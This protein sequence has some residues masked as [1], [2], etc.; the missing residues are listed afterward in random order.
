MTDSPAC[1]Q[2]GEVTELGG[3]EFRVDGEVEP[4]EGGLFFE[5]GAADPSVQRGGLAAGDLVLA[6][7]L[8]ELEVAEFAGAGL[9]QASVERVEHSREFEFS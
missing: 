3:G 8:E 5:P 4:F 6:E 7:H 9:A 2:R 1:S